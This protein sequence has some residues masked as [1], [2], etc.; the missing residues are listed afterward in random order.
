MLRTILVLTVIGI[1]TGLFASNPKK[2]N[3]LINRQIKGNVQCTE[4][5]QALP[6]AQ[7]V[8]WNKETDFIE[9]AKLD[10]KGNFV[11]DNLE[12]GKYYVS[13]SHLGYTPIIVDNIS[14]KRRKSN[15]DLKD[16]SLEETVYQIEE[17]TI[18]ADRINNDYLSAEKN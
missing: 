11:F 13:I 2:S 9:V 4:T 18:K 3:D 12:K 17:I 6:Y 8:L 1:T 10:Q 14:V 7:V 16:V 5:Q 15:I